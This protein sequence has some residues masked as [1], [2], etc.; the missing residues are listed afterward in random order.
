VYRVLPQSHTQFDTTFFHAFVWTPATLFLSLA[1]KSQISHIIKCKMAAR[2]TQPQGKRL[3]KIKLQLIIIS[4]RFPYSCFSL[5]R[6]K[7]LWSLRFFFFCFV[8]AVWIVALLFWNRLGALAYAIIRAGRQ[9]FSFFSF[10]FYGSG[11]TWGILGLSWSLWFC[12][13][14]DCRAKHDLLR[15]PCNFPWRV[16]RKLPGNCSQTVEPLSFYD[17][18][19]TIKLSNCYMMLNYYNL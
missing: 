18:I 16:E 6:L 10:L 9:H 19:N 3:A 8:A 17:L 7:L 14:N 15:L 13:D 2:K 5:L 1:I 4:A 11:L 12:G